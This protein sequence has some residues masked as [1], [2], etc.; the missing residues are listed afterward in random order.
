MHFMQVEVASRKR[1][2][3]ISSKKIGTLSL[4]AAKK[5]LKGD[6]D[7]LLASGPD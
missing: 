4:R 7:F 5:H 2:S 1:A 6:R 3:C